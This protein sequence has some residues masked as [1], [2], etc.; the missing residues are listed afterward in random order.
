MNLETEKFN[1][2]SCFKVYSINY[3]NQVF[4]VTNEFINPLELKT[5]RN[6]SLLEAVVV[7]VETFEN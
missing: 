1:I 6:K 4:Q 5:A 3:R 7:V 2:F